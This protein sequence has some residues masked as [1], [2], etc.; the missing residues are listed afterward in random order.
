MCRCTELPFLDRELF[1][2]SKGSAGSGSNVRN[3]YDNT[4]HISEMNRVENLD[5]EIKS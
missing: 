2:S 3:K 1:Y 5:L 4:Y